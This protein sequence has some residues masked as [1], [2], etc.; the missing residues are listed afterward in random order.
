MKKKMYFIL[1]ML[2]GMGFTLPVLAQGI[3]FNH[4]NWEQ[5]KSA[6]TSQHKLIF[7]DFYTTWCAPC[8]FMAQTIFP[9]KDVGDFYNKNFVCV[10][11][12][13]EKGEGIALAHKY[14]VNAYPTMMFTNEKEEVIHRAL[15]SSTAEEFI[16]QGKIALTASPDEMAELKDKY[17]KNEMTKDELYKY[18]LRVKAGGNDKETS[19]VF[20]KYFALAANVSA[21]MFNTISANVYSPDSKAFIYLEQHHDEFA[22]L[23][24]KEKVDN[25]IRKTYIEDVEYNRFKT[26]EEFQAAM[27]KLKA[28]VNL[29]EKEELNIDANYYCGTKD[30][31]RYMAAASKLADTYLQDDDFALSNLIGGANRFDLNKDEWLTVKAWA[32]RALAIKDNALNNASLAMVYKG[33]NDKEQALKYINKSL[34]DCQRDKETYASRIAMFKKEIEDAAY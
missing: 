26:D 27:A 3:E 29:T 24:G 19:E 10:Q 32:E 4:D 5:V 6:A 12:D 20:D 7:I 11:V 31:T 2:F 14:G 8:K 30:K 9:L 34:E 13:A 28:K 1:A 18:F 15:G 25:F 16:G 33:I 21:E 22:N 23:T 17:L